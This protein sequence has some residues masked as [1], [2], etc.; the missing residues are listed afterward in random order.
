VVEHLS[1]EYLVERPK[2]KRRLDAAL[3]VP[4]ALVVAQAGAG[5]TVL[6]NQ[7]AGG[8]PEIP[9]VW[10]DVET[11]DDDP[12]RFA[13]RLLAGL[14]VVRPGVM[15]LARMSAL[16]AGG[17]G[18]PLLQ[19]LASELASLP[20][21]VVVLDDLHH[22][23]N[24]RLLGDIGL[25]VTALPANVHLIISTRVDPAIPWSRLRLRNRLLEIR[26]SDLA[27]TDQEAAELLTR[28][29]RRD[30]SANDLDVLISRTEGWAAGLQLAALTLKF[31]SDADGFV[32]EFGGTDRLI[33]DYL[34][35]EVLGA[36]TE[37]G[38]ST[39]LRMSPL[40]TMTADLVDH[41]LERSDAQRLF[42]RLGQESMFL[43]AL[44]AHRERFRFHHLFRDL[45]RYRLR[46]D[47]PEEEARL[48]IRAAEFHLSHGDLTSAI[49]YLLQAREWGR[50][51]DAIMTRGSDIFE[52][53]EMT[54]VIRWISTVPEAAR[55]D[56][57]DVAL[58]LGLLVGMRGEAAR[59]VDI[60]TRVANDPRATA[61]QQS[62]AHAWISATT[63]WNAH[64]ADTIRASERALA[65]LEAHPDMAIPDVMHLTT[66]ELLA[67]V[68]IGSGG[69]SQFLAGNLTSADAWITRALGSEGVTYPPF[70]VGLL[71][72]LALL[73]VWCGRAA[74]A[75]LLAAEALETAAA[76]GLLTHPII[77]DAY[78]AEAMVAHERGIPDAAAAPL[79]DGTLRA[80]ANHRTQLAWISR[81]ARALLAVADGRFD[82]A[83]EFVDLSKHDA[84]SAP[85][86]VIL[87]RLVAVHMSALRRTGRSE[88]SLRLR[89][90][91]P[92]HSADVA[93]ETA[94]A[95][96]AL[97]RLEPARLLL[98]E[99]RRLFQAE[100]PR[101]DVQ[102]FAA[103]AWAAEL[104]G[105]HH[106]ALEQIGMALDRAEA[107]G[108]VEVFI[109]M[110]PVVLD[111]ITEV[112][113][114]RGGLSATILSRW[115]LT[116]P[117]DANAGLPE[118]LT[119]RE[120]E[121]LAYL[122]GHS[123][124]AELAKLCFVSVN[125]LKTHV[126]HIYRKLGVTGR[127]DAITRAREL[128]L[129]APVTPTA[130]AR[131]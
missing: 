116:Q 62:V 15:D 100:Q 88:E 128:G 35:E 52:R 95:L 118:P 54:T 122:P 94:A 26:Q 84:V 28:V 7:W 97:G 57:L 117:L 20:E 87:E 103:L 68:A 48:L 89:G 82:E 80:E 49:E 96:L 56:R 109:A 16:N 76:S 46:A 13:R 29:S 114:V 45:L 55:L 66:R 58:E 33:A 70:R 18:R 91:V 41:V 121:I 130:H 37:Q 126:M 2:L 22:L 40:D 12:V 44:D 38:R 115:R 25:L 6:L 85:A 60:L 79:R 127:S 31:Q 14:A 34:A 74:E 129:I 86:P 64:P 3:S 113:P 67:T 24:A 81:Y 93:F 98:T 32:S 42:E 4:L 107:D 92:P 120:L 106:I 59:A 19:A 78:F 50:A 124:T 43:V 1:T 119:E 8:H 102:R 112:A 101:G 47:H 83:L 36:I 51:L 110:D 9:F 65:L 30:I 53:G 111:L 27:M 5:K 69:R 75:E 105:D 123:T 63:Q 125:T 23:S 72:S 104:D 131:A 77:A 90:G 73:R 39:L 21:V 61:G 17:L 108:L 10:I 71:G 11:A 99:R